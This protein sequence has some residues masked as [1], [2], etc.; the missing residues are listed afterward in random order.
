MMQGSLAEKLRVLRAQRGLT[1]VQA[2]Q[3]TGVDRGTLSSLE[4]GVHAPYTPTLSKIAKGYGVPVEELLEE[5]APLASAPSASPSLDV[6][7]SEAG[8][9]YGGADLLDNPRVREWLRARGATWVA[10][11]EGELRE[12]VRRLDPGIDEDGNPTRIVGLV[13]DVMHEEAETHAL[14]WAPK[15]YRTLEPL[16]PV[17][18]D[19]PPA[20]QKQQRREQVRRLRRQVRGAYRR[21]TNALAQYANDLARVQEA[22]GKS[23]GRFELAVGAATRREQMVE[24]AF[25]GFEAE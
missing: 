9:R 5:A 11:T 4:R 25:A 19:A 18:P 20:E 17:D 6:G 1:L 21:R 13:E 16:L 2:S 23:P 15:E 22:M 14:L 24:A 10:M 8:Q 3:K 7:E 12:H